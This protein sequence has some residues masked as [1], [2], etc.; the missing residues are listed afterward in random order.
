M[1]R[2]STPCTS[3]W[4]RARIHT[5]R[6]L[7][8]LLL[9]NLPAFSQKENRYLAGAVP[10]EGGIVTFS[11]EIRVPGMTPEQIFDRTE[12]WSNARFVKTEDTDGKLL[13]ANKENGEIVCRGDEWL[14]FKRTAWV[15]D[16]TRIT[17]RMTLICQ[18]GVCQARISHIQYAYQVSD[19]PLPERF[20]AEERITDKYALNRKQDKLVRTI[21]KFRV[22]TID[23]TDELFGS[24]EDALTK[25]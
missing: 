22:Y 4:P 8:L 12:A 14:T 3:V 7:A 16:R 24:L 6:L 13:Y 25:P 18:P 5:L 21:G 11:K 1:Q 23:L 15:L 9:A 19:N 20:T 10:V 17:Y 2:F